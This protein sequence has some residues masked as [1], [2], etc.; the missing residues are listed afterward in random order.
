MISPHEKYFL[1]TM[2]LQILDKIETTTS[3]MD[4]LHCKAGICQ[5]WNEAIPK[6]F[7]EK[8]C[9]SFEFDGTSVPFNK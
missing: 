2:V 1:K 8:G 3:C 6:E 7:I 5:K 4:C 9:S